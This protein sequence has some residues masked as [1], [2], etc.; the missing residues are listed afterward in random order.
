MPAPPRRLRRTAGPAAVLGALLL[1]LVVAV[2]SASAGAGKDYILSVK[3]TSVVAGVE[4]STASAT[5]TNDAATQ[6]L[7]SADV[8]APDGFSVSDARIAGRPAPATSGRTIHLRNLSLAPGGSVTVTFKL[9]AP[10]RPGQSSLWTVEAKQANDFNGIGNDFTPKAGTAATTGVSGA[11]TL[12]WIV[13]PASAEIGHDITGTAYTPSAAAPSVAVVDGRSEGAQVVATATGRVDLSLGRPDLDA[14]LTGGTASL[15]AATF[16]DLR[17]AS[18]GT[19][20]LTATVKDGPHFGLSA[21]SGPF[22]IE[23]VVE[24]CDPGA[25][26]DPGKL[27]EDGYTFDLTASAARDTAFLTMTGSAAFSLTALDCANWTPYMDS[28]VLFDVTSLSREKRAAVLIKKSEINL[29]TDRGVPRLEMCF[30]APKPFVNS[31]EL[32]R[33][34]DWDLDGDTDAVYAGLLVSC[35][36]VD[37]SRQPCIT[38]RR[39]VGAGDGYIE[40]VMPVG[41]GDPLMRG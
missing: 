5:L 6:Q 29:Y 3:P 31:R 10:C 16:G 11:C 41:F 17:V 26:C 14:L 35:S 15:P 24:D 40:A 22:R 19:Y 9:R 7:G 34:F 30:A 18:V 32:T 33:R 20:S 36:K 23:E 1:L 25:P 39:K 37:A 2:P 8:T 27:I 38:Q 4:I 28:T 21:T 13:Q 12:A